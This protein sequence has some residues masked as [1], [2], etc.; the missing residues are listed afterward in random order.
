MT[1]FVVGF[2]CGLI[3]Y[4]IGFY[5]GRKHGKREVEQNELSKPC[6]E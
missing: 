3:N 6:N 5:F 2:I 4:W 1:E